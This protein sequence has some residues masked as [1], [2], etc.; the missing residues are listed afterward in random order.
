ML[1]WFVKQESYIYFIH[2]IFNVFMQED[3]DLPIWLP[4]IS[5]QPYI[6]QKIYF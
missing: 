5:F 2:S 6:I 1:V 3:Y 4:P